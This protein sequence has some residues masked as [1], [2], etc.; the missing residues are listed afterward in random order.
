MSSG[1]QGDLFGGLGAAPAAKPAATAPVAAPVK[2]PPAPEQALPAWRR[3]APPPDTLEALPGEAAVEPKTP[4]W[5]RME[6]PARRDEPRVL[7]VSQLTGQVKDLLEPQFGRVIVRGEVAN[8]RG[9][10]PRGHLYFALKDERAQIDVKVWA[11]QAQR[12]KFKL[13]D[14]MSLIIEGSLDVYEPQGRYSLIANKVEPEGMGA[15]ALAFEQLKQK[16][17]K[18]GLIGEGRTR[19]KR[20]LPFLPK[21]IGVVTSVTGAALRDFLKVLHRRHPKLSVLVADARMQGDEAIFEVRRA[22]RWLSKQSLDVIVITRGGG[23]TED[24]WTFNE[25]PVVRAVWDCPVPVVSA[26]GH[27]IDTTLCDLVADVR[28]PTPSAAAELLAPPL[29]DLEA[30]LATFKAR[31]HRAVE[32]HLV[33]ERS[34]LRALKA[35]LGDPR[36]ELSGQKLFLSDAAERLSRTLRKRHRGGVAELKE[37]ST[38]LQRARPQAQLQARRGELAQLKDALG[39]HLTRRLRSEREQLARHGKALE[40]HS[41]RPLLGQG[42]QL[43]ARQGPRAT[44]AMKGRVQRERDRLRALAGRLDA[45]SPLAVLSRGYAIAQRVDQ[46]VVRAA[47][48]VQVGDQLTL[49]LGG[50]DRLQVQVTQVKPGGK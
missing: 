7:S 33:H 27:E 34:D 29:A 20:P 35:Q 38:R 46:R 40:R 44:A 50:D 47:A 25:E 24:L 17:T 18:E 9:A 43:L 16:L 28:A 37:L 49:R 11:T 32:K 8:F 14:G 12:M 30:Q 2:P 48:D 21:R 39:R 45:L 15:Q 31:L 36:R 23:S 41:P 3:P 13:K 10:N 26:V 4:A 42:K 19:P 5:R 1:K 22:L 6:P